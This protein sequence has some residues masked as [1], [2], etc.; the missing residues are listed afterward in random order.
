MATI[1]I[2]RRN[3]LFNM[4][5]NYKIFID[6]QFVGKISNGAT[7]KFPTT[8]GQHTVTAKI[9][10]CG[11]PNISINTNADETK[12]LTI[13][14]YKYSGWLILSGFGM[15]VFLPILKG[16]MGFSYANYLLIPIFLLPFYYITIGRKKYLTLS[17]TTSH[18]T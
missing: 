11:S 18:D 7:K 15:I 16:I 9:D 4:A 17:E 1:E 12:C 14:S 5:R 13:G 10:W 3:E 6:G 2:K 8:A